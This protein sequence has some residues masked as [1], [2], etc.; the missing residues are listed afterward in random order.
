MTEPLRIAIVGAGVIGAVHAR[1]VATLGEDGVLAAVVD[2]EESRGRALAEQYGVPFHVSAAEAYRTEKIDIAAICL[3]SAFHAAAVIE[4]LEAG[5]HVIVEKPIDVTLDAAD[6]VQAAER[7]TGRTVSVISQRRFQPVASFI[8]RSIDEGALGRVTS[9]VVES[10]F[11]RAQEYY[12]SGDWRGTAAIDGGGA[13]MN[14]GIHA[15]DLLLWMLG[16]PVSV[17]AKTGRLAHEGIEV[18][19]VAGATIEFESGAIGLLLASTAAYPGLPVRLAVHGSHGTAVMENEGGWP[20]SPRPP[21]R[22]PSPIRC[23]SA[24]CRKA[25]STSTW[26]IVGSTSTWWGRSARAAGPR[27]PPTTDAGHCRSC[28]PCTSRPASVVRSTSTSERG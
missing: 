19:D 6:R 27:S 28:S 24:M 3:P 2:V 21:R 13:L 11:F 26:R 4:A 20:S 15:L 22:S 17:S 5:V 1:L 12:E 8:R 25:G 7:A 18:E 23:S 14:Q 10:A 16:R 9:G